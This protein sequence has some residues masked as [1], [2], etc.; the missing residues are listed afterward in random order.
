VGVKFRLLGPLR[1]EQAGTDTPIGA[2][3]LRTLLAALLLEANTAVSADRLGDVMWNG[4]PPA[5]EAS[6]LY[7]HVMRLRRILGPDADRIRAVA[8]GYL[9]RVEPGELDS[10][11]FVNLCI[12]GHDHARRGLWTQASADLTAALCLWY[13]DPVADV[14]NLDGRHTQ[15]HRLLEA[16]SRALEG[17]IEAD[18]HLGRHADLLGELRVLATSQ[19]LSEV[20]HRQLMLALYRADRRAE[21][22]EV[23]QA[24]RRT[25]VE[26]LG[27]EP[28]PSVQQLHHQ[29]LSA[30]PELAATAPA[31]AP[32][33]T[34]APVGAVR[35]GPRY[36]LPADTRVF[37]GRARELDELTAFT[38]QA[39]AGTDAGMV[40][41][42]AVDGM[43]GI[44]KSALAVHA[45]HR[46]RGKFPDGQ[47]FLD[48]QGH[49]TGLEPMA[50]GDALN[51]LLRSLGTPPQ[52]IPRDLGERAAFYRDRLDGTRT[53]II[54][55]NAAGT[56]QVRPLIPASSG[57]LVL[58]TSRRRLA[59]LDDA[60]SLALDVL[61][62]AD[63]VALLHKVAGPGRIPADHHAVGELIALCGHLP[64]ALRI[65]A[66]RLRHRRTLRVEEVVAQLREE[67]TRLG[68]L[69][70][71]ERDLTAVFESS[72]TAL[73]AA[74]QHLFR[75]LGLLPG[76][77]LDPYA[78]A[79]L[80]DTD[81]HTAERVLESLL[82]HNL[83]A[84]RAPGR[85]HMHDLI[86]A[87][88]RTLGQSV[89]AEDRET[90]LDRLLNYYRHTAQAA[91]LH[92]V[93]QTRPG[94]PPATAPPASAPA[95]PDRAAALDWMRA[96]RANLVAAVT[97]TGTRT[98]P[99]HVTAL[100][101]ALA[102]FLYL[103]GPWQQA[104]SL[105]QAA[106]AA[107][108]EHSD[109]GA[110]ANARCD[111]G[112]TQ[113]TAGEYAAAADLYG[114]A[115]TIYQEVGERLGEA[116]ARCNLGSVRYTA[117]DYSA[118]AELYERALATY[119]DL[120]D[121]LG[122]AGALWELG[123]MRVATAD[124]PSAVSLEER[125]LRIYQELGHRQGEAGAL[126]ELGRVRRFTGDYPAAADLCERAL[127]TYQNLGDRQGEAGILWELG[128]GRRSTGDYPA[129]AGLLERALAI[130]QELGHRQ[131]EAFTFCNLG[132]VRRPNGDH[133]AAADSLER[134][135]AIFQDLGH[136]LGQ[137]N[138]LRELGCVRHETGDHQAAADLLGRALVIFQDVGSSQG[139]A[140]TLN[141][142]G[143]LVA[144]TTGPNEALALYRQAL[145][146]A[147]KADSPIEEAYA[148]EG[149]ARCTARLGDRTTALADLREAVA[150]YQRIGAPET[151]AASAY[152]AALESEDTH[153]DGGVPETGRRR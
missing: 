68:H 14:P 29:I 101:G 20:V 38:N 150:L 87:F 24:L 95:L 41:I 55:D 3:K 88:A 64:L 139:E 131:G 142:T 65:T 135:L 92:L 8:P 66:A 32:R 147:R 115:L 17:R 73:P 53:L 2:N 125:A 6:S 28:S 44:G 103:E 26:E 12:S 118:A 129:A 144:E 143:A 16:R 153:E 109:R 31:H 19:P 122:E 148:L 30:D 63:A 54:L 10:D 40:V 49:S 132:S 84:Q 136:R 102:A 67:A 59:G 86:R 121:R 149:C 76:P 34:P 123:R 105:H 82:D 7:N 37:T 58:V 9:I 128:E 108:H 126:W 151:D 120:G 75:H 70:D 138:A 130:F 48:L 106:A 116:N 56:A 51:F 18:L 85:Y 99:P 23:F 72:Y 152:L 71:E 50:A 127:A 36:Q 79:N 80:L 69:Q 112:R 145:L 78:V 13:G 74:E 137:A 133:E 5:S 27:V 22:L 81:R 77:D 96:E 97:H 134:A 124:Y 111:L 45:A 39:P 94:P 146:I 57:C 93:R 98:R 43:A 119:Q 35:R 117:G 21:A 47:L 33:P 89:P 140:E 104:I 114:Q 4:R 1:L 52:L 113:I 107:A 62:E 61:P 15:I 25:L 42:C 60:Y 100:T 141:S 91:D 11:A 110:E 90:A 46:V 83:L